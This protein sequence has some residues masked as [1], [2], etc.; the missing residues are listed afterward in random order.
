VFHKWN[1]AKSVHEFEFKYTSL[2]EPRLKFVQR[3][4]L[5]LVL[6]VRVDLH[7]DIRARVTQNP[8]SRLRINQLFGDQNR[9]QRVPECME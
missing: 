8:L 2:N 1:L 6:R 5:C 7:C 3:L 4:P 9:C